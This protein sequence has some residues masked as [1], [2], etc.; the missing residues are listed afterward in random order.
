MKYIQKRDSDYCSMGESN[1]RGKLAKE[2]DVSERY[3]KTSK[4]PIMFKKI[5]KNKPL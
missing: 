4:P 1:K 2:Q 3:K 5:N